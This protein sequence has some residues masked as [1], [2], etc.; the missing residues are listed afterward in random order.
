MQ[1]HV[2]HLITLIKDVLRAVP[3]VNVPI[4]DQNFL[5]LVGRILGG[6]RHIVKEAKA[7]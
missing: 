5:A 2:K 4:H 7:V 3:M 6:Y 1:A